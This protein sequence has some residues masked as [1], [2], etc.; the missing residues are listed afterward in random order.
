MFDLRPL[1]KTL[2]KIAPTASARV[3]FRLFFRRHCKKP[4]TRY[5]QIAVN[6]WDRREANDRSRKIQRDL[7]V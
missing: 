6:M 5:T 4:R 1:E 3:Q 7:G 2:H